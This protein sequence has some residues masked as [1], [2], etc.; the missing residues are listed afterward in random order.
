MGINAS[1]LKCLY[2]PAQSG[3]TR[4]VEELIKEYTLLAAGFGDGDINIIISANNILLVKQTETRMRADLVDDDAIIQG[5]IFSWTSREKE[6]NISSAEL[7]YRIMLE[8]IEMV[9][10]CAHPARLKYL[11]EMLIRISSSPRFKKKINLWIDEADKSIN[12]WQKYESVLSMASVNQVTLVSATFDSVFK[13]YGELQVMGFYKTHPECYRRLKD[14]I[15]VEENFACGEAVDY[16]RQVLLKHREALVR[17]GKR[18]FIPGE[19]RKASHDAIADLLHKEFGFVV[20]I[21]NGTRKEILVPGESAIDLRRYLSVGSDGQLP[22]EFSSQLAQL[23]KDNN[24]A[25]FPLAITGFYCVERGVT[26]Q[27]GPKEGVHDGFLFDYGIIP[28]IACKAEAYQ[29]MARLFGNVGHLPTYKPV[30]IYTSSAMISKVEKQEE[31]AVNLAR[32]VHEQG[33]TMVS[34][35][36]IKAAQNF[37]VER[38][39]I[40]HEAEFS[41]LD[42]A[43]KFVKDLGAQ[44][45]TKKAL[46]KDMAGGFYKSSTSATKG[47]L[48]YSSLKKEMAGWGKTSNMDVHTKTGSS[49]AR[50]YISYKDLSDS[51]SVVF[52]CRVLKRVP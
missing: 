22:E 2:L 47:V 18:S 35:K 1:K 6:C 43:N 42:D 27:C 20:I 46:E 8:E 45:K 15:K 39:W 24:W 26:F 50:M 25:R 40:L 32:M 51:A 23:Y 19:I 14:A 34:K 16:V 33:L 5:S 17:P 49:Y 4:K 30:H 10:V 41:S 29:T 21:I 52:S 11:N 36:H 44:G 3:K 31:I 48:S 38:S 7:A 37:D 9:V 12:L 28:P 13:V